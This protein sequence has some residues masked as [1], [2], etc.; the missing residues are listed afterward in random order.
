M[1]ALVLGLAAVLAVGCG[2]EPVKAP[3]RPA[4]VTQAQREALAQAAWNLGRRALERG[5]GPVPSL[6]MAQTMGTLLDAAG[7][8]SY[9]PAESALGIEVLNP[10][11]LAEASRRT[12]WELRDG[13]YR[14]GNAVLAVVPLLMDPYFAEQAQT[15]FDTWV[16]KTGGAG[17]AAQNSVRDWARRELGDPTATSPLQ[18]DKR[19]A[20]VLASLASLRVRSTSR[21]A[22]VGEDLTCWELEEG[23]YFWQSEDGYPAAPPKPP[24]EWTAG[25]APS[26]SAERQVPLLA[27]LPEA[28]REGPLAFPRISVELEGKWKIDEWVAR[29]S[30]ELAGDAAP[31]SSAPGVYWLSDPY[32][33]PL[34]MG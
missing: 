32:G 20:F 22:R 28:L 24:T 19:K 5:Q 14:G 18:L 11:E 6:A 21:V 12:L 3:A 4:E 16:A 29:T 23:L 26:L 2:P 9:K 34:V 13:P 1:R 31:A 25:T 33:V 17:I 7:D 27:I 8:A 30:L 15:D 10:G